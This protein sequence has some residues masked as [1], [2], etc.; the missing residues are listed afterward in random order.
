[1]TLAPASAVA[2]ALSRGAPADAREWLTVDLPMGLNPGR[3]GII[4]AVEPV[5]RTERSIELATRAR[6]L[7]VIRL[8]ERGTPEEVL[9]RAFASASA[10]LCEENGVGA[11]ASFEGRVLLGVTALLIE[12]ETATVAF[13]PPGQ[14]LIVQDGLVSAI[15]E[16][17]SW[18]PDY[19]PESPLSVVETMGFS[20]VIAPAM[21]RTELKP[22]DMVIV[23]SAACGQALAREVSAAGLRASDLSYLFGH[24]P[25]FVLDLFRGV[26]IRD[27]VDAAAVAVV[28]FPPLPSAVQVRTLADVGRRLQERWRAGGANVRRWLPSPRPIAVPAAAGG[29]TGVLSTAY[30]VPFAASPHRA[31]ADSGV[32]V[33]PAPPAE[34]AAGVRANE[35]PEWIR[36]AHRRL[37]GVY[38]WFSPQ[39]AS[40][41][42]RPS[43]VHQFGLP[44][45]HGVHLYRGTASGMGE[46]NWRSLLPRLPL[47]QTI[48][49]WGLALL[50]I[51]ALLLGGLYARQQA[52]GDSERVQELIA[53]VDG[54]IIAARTAGDRTAIRAELDAAQAALQD[55]E[56]EGAGDDLVV[57]RRQEIVRQ[58][59]VLDSV[60]RFTNVARVGS[61]PAELD[62]DIAQLVMTADGAYAAGGG[63]FQLQPDA[64]QIVR[65]LQPGQTID[66]AKVDELFGAAVDVEGLYAT[67]GRFLYRLSAEG[68]WSA[69]ALEEI[70]GQGRWPAGPVSAFG[71]NFYLLVPDYRN[72]YKFPPPAEGQTAAQP[73]DWVTEQARGSLN[74]AVDFVIDGN[75]YVLL[76]DG[77]VQTFYKG[78]LSDEITLR[79]D[80]DVP[81]ALASGAGTDALY[82]AVRD[83]ENGRIIVFD[84]A[85][86]KAYQ[87]LL[88]DG[89]TTGDANIP[90]PYEGLRDIAIDEGAG[91]VYLITT[92]AVWTAQYAVPTDLVVSTQESEGGG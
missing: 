82:M 27:G 34:A 6:E 72:I 32:P 50:L 40:T 25:D 20:P 45:A 83:G 37:A 86:T 12:D 31:A 85:G 76:S 80:G 60:I 55:A 22:G 73:V 36:G 2:F 9:T 10:A 17:G 46:E 51:I 64:R 42:R 16:L 89:F 88:P 24:D 47:I 59:D 66:D 90:S 14:T 3:R 18:L 19:V 70:T 49:R 74:L 68:T 53:V 43:P 48:M 52:L 8:R 41:W 5:V 91:V 26:F 87:L 69:T 1:M 61:L 77:R 23:G 75:I 28:G 39:W 56:E 67:D 7:L 57:A 79:L 78:E 84:K 35:R 65:V 13:V 38:E 11:D 21:V 81:L 4:V 54:H 29:R 92:D 44:G 63:L 71:G 15:P 33:S 58:R 30:D 62:G